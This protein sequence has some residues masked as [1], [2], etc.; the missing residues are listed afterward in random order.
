MDYEKEIKILQ[1]NQLI[2]AVLYV[3]IAIELLLLIIK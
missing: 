1:K 3:V 2:Q